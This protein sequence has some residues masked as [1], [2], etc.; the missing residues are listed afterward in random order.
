MQLKICK[1]CSVYGISPDIS[2]SLFFGLASLHCE[3]FY[4]FNF[5][6]LLLNV[7]L[8]KLWLKCLKGSL[9]GILLFPLEDV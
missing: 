4:H 5:L 3:L 2:Y 7:V 6:L 8:L 1:K 9:H